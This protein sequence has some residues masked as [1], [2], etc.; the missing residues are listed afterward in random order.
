MKSRISYQKQGFEWLLFNVVSCFPHSEHILISVL[1]FVCEEEFAVFIR[2]RCTFFLCF[3][4]SI[5]FGVTLCCSSVMI[6]CLYEGECRSVRGMLFSSR[7]SGICCLI[8][9][10]SFI[11]K[12]SK[13]R[14]NGSYTLL[15]PRN[16][17]VQRY[18]GD[19]CTLRHPT[20]LRG[21]WEAALCLWVRHVLNCYIIY[22]FKVLFRQGLGI[23]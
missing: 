11:L 23:S 7:S 14:D 15:C 21:W 3:P 9:G 18:V 6:H 17:L 2:A 13:I 16:F 5:C 1:S 4:P 22:L 10:L 12:C 8:G 19:Y 20:F